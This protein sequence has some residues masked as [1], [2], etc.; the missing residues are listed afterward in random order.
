MNE[1]TS[2]STKA[3]PRAALHA[4]ARAVME[5]RWRVELRRMAFVARDYDSEFL[6]GAD[7]ARDSLADLAARGDTSPRD[8]SFSEQPAAAAHP[9]GAG[10]APAGSSRSTP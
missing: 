5:H 10:A 7:D 3:D 8:E 9:P 1:S 6:A 2:K 4:A